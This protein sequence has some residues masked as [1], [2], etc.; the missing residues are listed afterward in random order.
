MYM[1]N[2]LQR[3][4]CNHCLTSIIGNIAEVVEFYHE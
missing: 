4:N 3:Q 1:D 2:L